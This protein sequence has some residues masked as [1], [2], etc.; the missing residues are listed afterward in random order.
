[1]SFPIFLLHAYIIQSFENYDLLTTNWCI[2]IVIVLLV[3]VAIIYAM[4][5]VLPQRFHR[6]FGL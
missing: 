5:I 3:T 6:Y 4:G 1:M 2:N